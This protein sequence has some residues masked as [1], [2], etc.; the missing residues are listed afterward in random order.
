MDRAQT[1][2]AV[3]DKCVEKMNAPP[4]PE[5]TT[6]SVQIGKHLK[7]FLDSQRENKNDGTPEN[8]GEVITRLL[9]VFEQM[10]KERAAAKDAHTRESEKRL[11]K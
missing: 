10:V 8:N 1:S 4:K 3:L 7:P 11:S 2:N 6:M 9:G 5:K